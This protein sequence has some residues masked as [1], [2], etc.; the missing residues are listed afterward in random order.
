MPLCSWLMAHVAVCGPWVLH[1]GLASLPSCLHA[2]KGLLLLFPH[3][4]LFCRLL[5]REPLKKVQFVVIK[6]PVFACKG[7]PVC[8][9]KA[10]STTASTCKEAGQRSKCT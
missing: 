9:M 6:W 7:D 10:T 8:K 4:F 1:R 5:I 3:G 2:L